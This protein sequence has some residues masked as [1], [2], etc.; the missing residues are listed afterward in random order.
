M[1]E[2]ESHARYRLDEKGDSPVWVVVNEK[3]HHGYRRKHMEG[4]VWVYEAGFRK[5]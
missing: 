2:N 5:L 1:E 4:L 3:E